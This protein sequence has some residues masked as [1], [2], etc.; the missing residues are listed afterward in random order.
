MD[1]DSD[2]VFSFIERSNNPQLGSFGEL[3]YL[4]YCLE[5][6]KLIRSFHSER[7]DFIVDNQKIDVK[8]TRENLPNH[9]ERPT[10]NI[11]NKIDGVKYVSVEFNIEGV[12]I[13]ENK[14]LLKKLSWNQLN[15][16]YSDWKKGIGWKTN[17]VQF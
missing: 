4:Q 8:T 16:I 13:G 7:A 11:Q 9:I 6:G 14:V 1:I 3:V 15:A 12:L 17:E 2:N 5:E 10:L